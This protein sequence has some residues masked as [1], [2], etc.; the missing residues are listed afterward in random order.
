MIDA[1]FPFSRFRAARAAAARAL[2]LAAGLAAAA[3]TPAAGQFVSAEDEKRIGAQEH[4]KLVAQYG[5]VYDDPE[6]GFYIAQI[7]GRVAAK[8]DRP[9]IEYTFTLLD[10]DVVNAFALPGGYIYISRALLALANTEAEVAGVLAHEV[11]HVTARHTAKR[12]DRATWTQLGAG[13]L[14]ILGQ[15]FLNTDLLGQVGQIAGAA[16]VAGFSRDQEYEADLLG[17]R[18]MTGVGYNPFA[19]G[20]FLSQ[21]GRETWLSEQITGTRYQPNFLATHPN[22]PDRVRRAI[23]AAGNVAEAERLPYMRENYLEKI[24][25]LAWGG[26]RKSGFNKGR[27]FWHPELRF[28]FEAPPQFSITNQA[29]AVYLRGPSE[30]VVKFDGAGKPKSLDPY[31]Y[32]TRE[33]GAKLKFQIA[34]PLTINGMPAATGATQVR[35]KDGPR[36][37]RLVV[38]RADENTLY[39]MAIYTV[40]K[41]T[42]ILDEALRRFVFSFRRLGRDEAEAVAPLRITV[43]TVGAGDTV[44]SLAQ[45]MATDYPRERFLV[46]NGMDPEEEVKPG[47]KVKM[48]VDPQGR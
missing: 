41:R 10:S 18:Y 24:E 4:P 12:I 48:I 15:Q 34:E 8:S 19:Q 31:R 29:D 3:A 38:I 9:D 26:S 39:R 1:V 32:L 42:N 23:A 47:W 44:A 6:M 13:L 45:E 25:G 14:G 36:D 16:H 33:W 40:P 37:L 22:T 11:G 43:R 7:G 17:V 21:L 28:F 35:L 2:V 46:I 30:T 20:D 5:G 27:Q